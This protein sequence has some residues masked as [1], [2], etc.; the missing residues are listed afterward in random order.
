MEIVRQLYELAEAFRSLGYEAE[1]AL[2]DLNPFYEALPYEYLLYSEL[3]FPKAVQ[4]TTNP[5]IR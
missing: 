4:E 3:P 2:L 1:T 5:V